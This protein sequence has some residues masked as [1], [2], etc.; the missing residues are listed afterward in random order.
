MKAIMLNRYIIVG[1][2]SQSITQIEN[3]LAKYGHP[4]HTD[5]HTYLHTC[6][7]LAE[8]EF[9]KFGHLVMRTESLE[10]CSERQPS[11]DDYEIEWAI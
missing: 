8:D 10:E 5:I 11:H 4:P 1:T 3:N 9:Y 2:Y 6:I 7:A